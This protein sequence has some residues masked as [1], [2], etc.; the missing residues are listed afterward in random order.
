MTDARLPERFLTDRRILLLSDAHRSS[1]I[2]AT[3]Y[4]VA[5]RTE[6]HLTPLDVG[7][8]PTFDRSAIPALVKAG[9][10]RT[11]EDGWLDTEFAKNQTSRGELEGLE[12]GRRVE[13]EKKARQRAH[14]RGEHHLCTPST[15]ESLGD[16]PGTV[17]G[18]S[19]GQ[20]RTGKDRTGK[21]SEG[22][23]AQTAQ[24]VLDWPTAKPGEGKPAA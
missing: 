7:L 10:W 1:Y 24:K 16:V 21:A 12:H 14:K 3:L 18:D 2:M 5:N 23:G 13:R 20:D 22:G 9:L 6:G 11:T 17:P 8:I 15:C 4:A 19:T